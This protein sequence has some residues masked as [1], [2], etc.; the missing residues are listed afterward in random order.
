MSGLPPFPL[1]QAS[2]EKVV[3]VAKDAAKDLAYVT[4][5]FAVLGFQQAQVRRRELEKTLGCSGRGAAQAK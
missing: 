5:G 4:V 1:S 2:V 3:A